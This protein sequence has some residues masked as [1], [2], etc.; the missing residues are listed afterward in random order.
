M[1]PGDTPIGPDSDVR[2]RT[3]R[4]GYF[5]LT[6]SSSAEPRI[7]TSLRRIVGEGSSD[8]TATQVQ[9]CPTGAPNEPEFPRRGEKERPLRFS[10]GRGVRR[11]RLERSSQS[12]QFSPGLGHRRPVLEVG[13]GARFHAEREP[14]F[15]G[16]VRMTLEEGLTAGR[17]RTADRRLNLESR[18]PK[19][20]ETSRWF[21]Q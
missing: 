17:G 12:P 21:A 5:H 14:I 20:Q 4:L 16:R 19:H 13:R 10:Q 9:C 2:K 6:I 18:Q 11:G 15:A 7:I 1:A 8:A 3:A